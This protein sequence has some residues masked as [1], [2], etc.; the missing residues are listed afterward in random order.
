MLAPEYD[1]PAPYACM[2]DEIARPDLPSS[3]SLRSRRSVRQRSK[4]GPATCLA[5]KYRIGRPIDRAIRMMCPF[6][7][8]RAKLPVDLSNL[9]R[10]SDPSRSCCFFNRHVEDRVVLRIQQIDESL[11][12]CVIVHV[13]TFRESGGASEPAC[14]QRS[15]L[16]CLQGI[17]PV[18]AIRP[19]MSSN[20]SS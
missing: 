4:H 7:C 5:R 11:D 1:E 20:N 16:S 18:R 9:R 3:A 12:I 14:S 13:K 17:Q 19:V 15:A 2:T 10:I 6:W 8:T